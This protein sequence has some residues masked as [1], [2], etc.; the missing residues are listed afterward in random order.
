M[1]V[2][3]NS[4]LFGQEGNHTW[5]YKPSQLPSEIMDLRKESTATTLL[6]HHNSLLQSSS[7]LYPQGIAITISH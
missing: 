2:A 1:L 7:S 6:E 3:S 4:Y 5:Y